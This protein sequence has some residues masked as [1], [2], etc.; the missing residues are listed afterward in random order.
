MSSPRS[1]AKAAA[2]KARTAAAKRRGQGRAAIQAVR[3][4]RAAKPGAS[5]EVGATAS[6]D[7]ERLAALIEQS[8]AAGRADLLTP[9]R[10]RP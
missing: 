5:I 1:A 8:L 3:R 2:T 7:A 6:S 10:F 4:R 9:R